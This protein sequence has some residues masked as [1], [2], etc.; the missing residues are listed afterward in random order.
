MLDCF[1]GNDD[2]DGFVS[3]RDLLSRAWPGVNPVLASSMKADGFGDVHSN[4]VNS[5][6]FLK[7]RGAVS[8]AA[9]NIQDS[10]ILYELTRESIPINMLPE[11]KRV[12]ALG[13]HAFIG[14]LKNQ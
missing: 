8:L 3:E 7:C 13:Y 10:F 11:R 2:I 1:E 12:G 6:G 5:A 9:R 14:G 4:Y